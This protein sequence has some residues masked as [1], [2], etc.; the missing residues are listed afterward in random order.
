MRPIEK[1]CCVL[2][3]CLSTARVLQVWPVLSNTCNKYQADV[4][5]VERCCRCIRFAV[6]CLGKGSASLLT[7]LVTQVGSA[8]RE[9]GTTDLRFLCTE[10]AIYRVFRRRWLESTVLSRIRASCI[11]AASW[12]T[13]TGRKRDVF[14]ACWI[15][16]RYCVF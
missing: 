7:P 5:I 6:R 8:L 11:W 13:S 3:Y 2:L 9:H 15:C 16:S 10:C 12:W 14:K 4:R 1:S